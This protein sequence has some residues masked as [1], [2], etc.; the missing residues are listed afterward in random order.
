MTTR[1]FWRTAGMHLLDRGDDGWLHVTPDF[2]RAYFSRPEL[3]PVEESC[4]EEIAL[5]KSLMLDPF[6][7]ID[8]DK[9]ARLADPDVVENYRLVLGFRDKLAGAGTLEAAYLEI[10]RGQ[11][12]RTPPIF[13]DQLAHVILRNALDECND[14]IRLRAAELFFRE[15]KVSRDG[16]AVVLADH[17]IVEFYSRSG[18]AGGLGQLLAESGTTMRPVELD[19]LREENSD[20]YWERS[21]KFDMVVDFRTGRPARIAFGRCVETWLAHMLGVSVKV[22]DLESINDPDWR[23]HIGLDRESNDILN[24]LFLGREAIP[25][26]L[27]RIAALYKMMIL[28]EHLVTEDVRGR[29]IYLALAMDPNNKIAMM[30]Q[31]LL[32]NLPLMPIL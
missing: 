9:L 31:N 13:L 29:P 8:D 32:V 5:H 6:L 4:S 11:E 7:V 21:D 19:V 30:P 18:G 26:R 3:L 1:D 22:D 28:D 2:L 25:E 14:P 17:D 12:G 27:G 24:D 16:D 20:L 10:V 15:Q 23:W